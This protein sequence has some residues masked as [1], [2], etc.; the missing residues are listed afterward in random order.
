MQHDSAPAAANFIR[1]LF[2]AISLD[3][4]VP[5]RDSVGC[6]YIFWLFNALKL[7][8][9]GPIECSDTWAG[10]GCRS[11]SQSGAKEGQPLTANCRL[12][13]SVSIPISRRLRNGKPEPIL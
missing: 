2:I 9:K 6:R 11:V 10:D 4:E 8:R 7:R 12:S 1:L 3:I 5:W 13:K